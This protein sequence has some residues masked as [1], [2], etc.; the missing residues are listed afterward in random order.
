MGSLGNALPSIEI[1]R[2]STI[3]IYLQVA[4]A[5]EE[6]ILSG[7]LT[8]G[9]RLESENSLV[10]R[11]GL[12]R[13]TVRQGIQ[14]LAEKGLVTRT[15]G[16]GTH[17][18][19]KVPLTSSR[20]TSES[21]AGAKGS[22]PS[23]T[24]I[25]GFAVPD[26]ANPFFAEIAQVV[27]RRS[28]ELSY[29]LLTADTD[30]DPSKELETI[31]R[32]KDHVDGLIIAAPRASDEELSQVLLGLPNVVLI[33]R[34][35][36]GIASVA[37]DVGVGMR[38]SIAHLAAMG[39]SSIGY[40]GGPEQSRAGRAIASSL[41]DAAKEFDS[42]VREIAHVQANHTGGFAA[43]DLVIA[44]GVT[45]VVAHNDLIAFGLISRLV[46]RGLRVPE[47]ISVVGCDN[48]P[49]SQ[50]LT[51]TLT[52]VAMDRQRLGKAAVDI[53]ARKLEGED[54]SKVQLTI[55][56]QLIVRNSTSVFLR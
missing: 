38:Q 29:F 34:R 6:A 45:A 4:A 7:V 48:I 51:P 47:D 37:V 14:D 16:V 3:P 22:R 41:H 31:G 28:R 27:E 26:L 43:A 25:F 12:S 10:S 20:T 54:T 49:F 32:M 30:E 42:E 36:D 53:L 1:D 8:P 2:T 39:H 5:F 40:V 50:M 56:S 24:E 44:S 11:L 9:S 19:N 17:V 35:I 13:P 21:A 33:N 52:S 46:Q 23:G 55:P 18:V 15:Q